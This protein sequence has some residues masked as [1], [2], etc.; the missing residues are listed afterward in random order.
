MRW[1]FS[2]H[3]N[4]FVEK[5]TKVAFDISLSSRGRFRKFISSHF[6]T[7]YFTPDIYENNNNKDFC[8]LYI[9]FIYLYNTL[10]MSNPELCYTSDTQ[11][12]IVLWCNPLSVLYVCLKQL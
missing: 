6:T 11:N 5:R 12:I 4:E 8:K 1:E 9:R 2:N 3:L 10:S 7:T